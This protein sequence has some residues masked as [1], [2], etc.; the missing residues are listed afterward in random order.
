MKSKVKDKTNISIIDSLKDDIKPIDKPT[1]D[2]MGLSDDYIRKRLEDGI[3]QYETIYNVDVISISQ[4]QY[5]HV[6]RYLYETVIKPMRIDYK[7]MS[8]INSICDSY[9]FFTSQH[10]KTTSI[11]GFSILLGIPYTTLKNNK[12]TENNNVFIYIDIDK[13]IVVEEY[14]LESYRIL[15]P[16]SRII[17]VPNHT[18]RSVC[19]KISADREQSLTD[20]TEDGS[21]MSLALG[22]IEFGWIESAKEKKQVEMMEKYVLPSDLLQKYSSTE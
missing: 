12:Y 20:K 13:N 14:T 16:N 15:N 22:K 5:N 6:L 4:R 2:S 17:S 10:K 1:I 21:I 3:S 9:I 11:N 19:Q 8:I 7:N 18:F